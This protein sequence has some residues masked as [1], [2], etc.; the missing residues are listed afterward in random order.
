[1]RR[2]ATHIATLA[3]SVALLLPTAAPV[4]AVENTN[5]ATDLDPW[6]P[7]RDAA[8]S[9]YGHYNCD[10]MPDQAW[11]EKSNAELGS[12]TMPGNWYDLESPAD[13]S[14]RPYVESLFISNE[15]GSATGI[16]S[17]GTVSTSMSSTVG[18]LGVVISPFNLCDKDRTPTPQTTSCY[19]TPNRVGITLAYRKGD[20]QVGY[21]FSR[22]NDGQNPGTNVTLKDN[23]G[24]PIVID[25]NTE[26]LLTINLNTIGKSLRWT[27]MNGIPS[28]WRPTNL[29]TDAATIEV[30]AK[31][32]KMPIIDTDGLYS[33]N[34]SCTQ[35]PISSC[36]VTQSNADWLGLQ[37]VL[38]L[39]T[40]MSE[41]MTG[42]LFATEG[43]IM[44]SVEVGSDSAT[45]LPLI[46][47]AAA[48]SHLTATGET[49]LGKLHAYVPASALVQQLGVPSF[50]DTTAVPAAATPAQVFTT[51]REGTC[52][53]G[54]SA[55]TTT[56]R[57]LNQFDN[58]FHGIRIDVNGLTFSAPKMQVKAKSGALKAP[59]ARLTGS[60]YKITV[61]SG[62]TSSSTS[63]VNGVCKSKGCTVKLYKAATSKLSSALTYVGVKTSAKGSNVNLFFTVTKKTTGSASGKVQRGTRYIVVVTRKDTGALVSSAPVVLP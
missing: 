46:K 10:G 52:G 5:R 3:L 16:V 48:S 30:H 61:A 37:M 45:G 6:G 28:Y 7:C 19:A 41:A 17:G 47:Y 42:A 23:D 24:N 39:D 9:T 1:M 29:G 15:A 38:S 44:G 14:S 32:A 33:A 60:T 11:L 63:T 20:G 54:C 22:P 25:E 56:F 49:R 51:L 13:L 4:A 8:G 26:I 2:H 21:N 36:N 27:W 18:S 35:V 34:Q 31:L 50:T 59:T 53:A 12:E 40:T 58:E 43:A 62:S 57:E 55:G